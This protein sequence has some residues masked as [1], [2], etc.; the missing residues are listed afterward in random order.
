MTSDGRRRLKAEACSE[1]RR[2]LC[3]SRIVP[4]VPQF[5]GGEYAT[6]AELGRGCPDQSHACAAG[7]ARGSGSCSR[8]LPA[9]DFP[10]YASSGTVGYQRIRRRR[11]P[12]GS[13]A[14]AS[15]PPA[16][17]LRRQRCRC[18]VRRSKRRVRRPGS[19]CPIGYDAE[20]PPV[21]ESVGAQGY[22]RSAGVGQDDQERERQRRG[23]RYRRRRR[24]P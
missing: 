17:R 3:R 11:L 4:R 6:I 10:G 16:R 8:P 13:A 9:G 12:P 15:T 14:A 2:G 22:R 24:S 21:L 7:D 20:R 19:G 1:A 23:P 18:A 5:S